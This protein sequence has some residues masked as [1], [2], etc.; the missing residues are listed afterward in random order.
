MIVGRD[1]V[2]VS[3]GAVVANGKGR[4][5]L[6]KRSAGARD[7]HDKWEFPGG[8][9]KVFETRE[10]AARRNLLEK[11][12]LEIDITSVLNVYDVIDR[13]V[14]DHWVSATFLCSWTGGEPSNLIPDSCSEI[15]W[16][17]IEEIRQMELSRISRLNLVDLLALD[18]VGAGAVTG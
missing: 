8:S 12:G 16:F 10:Q 5:F 9:V 11:Y 4:Y 18:G 17:E 2:G 15:G 7:D 13:R 6:A 14:G 1:Y 3:A